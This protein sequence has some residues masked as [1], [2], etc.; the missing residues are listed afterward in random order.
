[1]N[2]GQIRNQVD[3]G[4]T[5]RIEEGEK[6]A[7][8]EEVLLSQHLPVNLRDADRRKPVARLQGSERRT[9]AVTYWGD[10]SVQHLRLTGGG[11]KGGAENGL[12]PFDAVHLRYSVGIEKVGHRCAAHIVVEGHL[13]VILKQHR[14]LDPMALHHPNIG[15]SVSVRHDEGE[16]KRRGRVGWQLSQPGQQRL[17]VGTV[18]RNED[19]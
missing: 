19:E 8:A 5:E 14:Q 15:L 1:M 13:I 7:P 4:S 11:G 9:R 2:A 10:A 18:R 17:A 16:R 12:R 6:R 3:A